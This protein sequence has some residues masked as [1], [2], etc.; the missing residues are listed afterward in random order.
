MLYT[1]QQ[2][3]ADGILEKQSKGTADKMTVLRE[4]RDLAA[5]IRGVLSGP[6]DIDEFSR[7]LHHGWKLKRS[8]GFGITS[9]FV[10]DWYEKA[11]AAGALGGKLLGAGGGGFLFLQAPP[12]AHEAIREALG[13]PRE[14]QFE[15]DRRGAR[16]IFISEHQV[17]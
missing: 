1:A 12:D 6:G 3:N 16:I 5:E 10:D 2:R 8:L 15:M 9:G 7:I 11:R 13:R 17:L 4:M 14:I